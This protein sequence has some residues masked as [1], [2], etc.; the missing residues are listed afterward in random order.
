MT[1]VDRFDP[2]HA[3]AGSR[4]AGPPEFGRVASRSLICAASRALIASFRRDSARRS[5]RSNTGSPWAISLRIAAT[6]SGPSSFESI[7]LNSPSGICSLRAHFRTIRRAIATFLFQFARVSYFGSA[8]A[9]EIRSWR[10]DRTRR[11]SM[12]ASAMRRASSSISEGASAPAIW[13]VSTAIASAITG[14][15]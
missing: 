1:L 15:G 5:Y 12:W 4:Y 3:T 2:F 6:L 13:R 14:S 8:R 11:A 10:R 7:S 9:R